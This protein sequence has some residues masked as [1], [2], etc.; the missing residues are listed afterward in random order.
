[1][2][3]PP[4]SPHAVVTSEVA[5]QAAATR[6]V[7]VDDH[8]ILRS[9]LAS[10]IEGQ[11]NLRVV[12]E[13]STGTEAVALCQEL[14][15]DVVIMDLSM[16]DMNGMDATER[17]LENDPSARVIALTMHLDPRFA[18]QALS[19][20]AVG[21]VLKIDALEELLAA[22]TAVLNDETYLSP[23]IAGPVV[24]DYVSVLKAG[25]A[26]EVTGSLTATERRVVQ[27]IAEGRSTKEIG[28][29]LGASSKTV[30]THPSHIFRKLDVSSVAEV[31]RYAIRE[32]L[33]PP[34]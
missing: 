14:K 27:L 34:E 13:A 12:G 8:A 7:L 30:A 24:A 1:M 21:Y 17:I 26:E 18:R 33:S 11:P 15:P 2:V 10:E 9:S 6:V 29:E 31:V 16:P 28:T 4:R 20:G 25:Q 23:R 3:L 32:G 22:I 19:A 5:E